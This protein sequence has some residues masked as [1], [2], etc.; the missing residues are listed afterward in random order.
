MSYN[1]IKYEVTPDKV[2]LVTINRPDALN[3]FTLEM[4]Q[5][6][7]HVWEAIMAD[8]NVNSVVLSAA[9]GRAFSTGAD[10][11]QNDPNTADRWYEKDPGESLGRVQTVC[12]N[13]WCVR[14]MASV[15]VGHFIG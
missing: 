12:G 11:K 14:C 8:D 13:R 1:T 9:P 2:A 3:A 7:E 4:C 6:F 5:E 15:V 10:V